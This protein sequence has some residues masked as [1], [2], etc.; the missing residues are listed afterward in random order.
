MA[1]FMQEIK[2][3]VKN[4]W[5]FTIIGVLLLI[6]GLYTI[7]NPLASFLGLSVFFGGL[8]FLNGIMELSFALGNRRRLHHWGWTIAAGILDI[9]LGF[10]LLLYPGLSMS[11]LPFLVGFYV[12][13]LG[14]SLSSYAFQLN[15]LAVKGW[16][17]ILA[18][19]ILTILF[20]LSMIFNPV[21]GIATIVGWTAFAFLIAGVVTIVFSLQLK[22]IKDHTE[23]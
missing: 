10:V 22:R 6:A 2:R 23:V 13:L 12:L 1:T 18:G 15:N 3:E 8:I 4:W 14:A 9:I 5:L 20:G 11:I 19:G 16:G 21:I 17:W 7:S